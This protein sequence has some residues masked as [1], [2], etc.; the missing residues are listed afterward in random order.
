MPDSRPRTA[1]TV[2]HDV[3]A[4][5]RTQRDALERDDL[6]T[7]DAATTR[8]AA[9]LASLDAREVTALEDADLEAIA[10]RIAEE[11]LA[12]EATLVRLMGS[13]RDELPAVARGHQANAAYRMPG[14][15]STFINRVS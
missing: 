7:F 4:L 14:R 2:L 12:N 9:L 3:L 8:R 15:P 6:D 11:D 10:A 5:A 1:G 13:I